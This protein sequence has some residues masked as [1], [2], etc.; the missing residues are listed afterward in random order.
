MV[1]CDLKVPKMRHKSDQNAQKYK[2]RCDRGAA[3][4][5]R[6]LREVGVPSRNIVHGRG[7]GSKS[8]IRVTRMGGSSC[9]QH[10]R[11]KY[12]LIRGT[13]KKAL[14]KHLLVT[15]PRMRISMYMF[16]F[17]RSQHKVFFCN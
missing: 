2:A 3:H 16:D 6:H 9:A 15:G 5:S 7:V 12:K 17:K 1:R 10:A 4:E 11:E 8:R 14:L 13:A